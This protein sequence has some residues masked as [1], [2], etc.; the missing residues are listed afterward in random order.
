MIR[1]RESGSRM[2][3]VSSTQQ[4][5]GS[6]LRGA[7]TPEQGGPT[8]GRSDRLLDL[9]HLLGGRR[10]RTLSEIAER[11]EISPR[12]AYRDLAD[13][14]Q[15]RIP[16]TRDE[17]GYRLLDDAYLRPLNL[18][19]EERAVL[20]LAID[21]PALQ[22]QPALSRRLEVVR[23]KLDRVTA[24]VEET[25]QG[26][27]LAGPDRSGPVADGMLDELTR[28]AAARQAVEIDYVSLSGGR[29]SWRGVDPY[30]VFHRS[31]A[32]YLVG[33][34]HL[35]NEPRLFRLDRIE[36]VRATGTGFERPGG[37]DLDA[38][39]EHCWGVFHGDRPQEVVL[40]FA[41]ELAPLLEHAR[42]HE[43]EKV[44]RLASGEVEY[45]VRVAHLDEVARWV[46]GFG[47]RCVVV[48]PEELKGRVKEIGAGVVAASGDSPPT[49]G[50]EGREE[51]RERE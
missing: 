45:R 43:G 4:S 14:S 27:W 49:C 40:R 23:S 5:L 42:H 18:T 19:V 7:S 48:E 35:H 21:N 26:L 38:Y 1:T 50:E 10:S 36:G 13:L 47:G 31:E 41:T 34:C 12:T 30:A 39:L 20:R 17:H 8:L 9:V 22:R 3:A 28:C 11:F 25:P 24:A 15:R 44:E 2:P 46:V 33:R 32:W 37:F 6:R 16:V 51:S 29:R